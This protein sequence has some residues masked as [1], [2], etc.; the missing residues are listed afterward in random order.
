MQRI[1]AIAGHDLGNG[2]WRMALSGLC[3]SLIGI[4]LSRFAYTPLLP[5]LIAE[6]WFAPSQAAYLGAANLAGYLAGALLGQPL[7]SRVSAVTVLR[8]MMLVAGAAFFA[9]A[10]PLSFFWFFWWRFA[11]GLSG[12]VLMVLI[13]PT[14]LPHV[15]PSRR[16]LIGG[17]IFVGIGCGIV[18]SGTLVPALLR[19]G[20]AQTWTG[21][22]ILALALTGVAWNGWPAAEPVVRQ[23][24]AGGHRARSLSTSST[25]RALYLEYAL[26]AFGLVPHMIFLVDFV[27]RGLRLGLAAGAREWVVFG[28]G[29]MAGPVLAGYIADRIG[30]R[31]ALRFAFLIQAAAVAILTVDSGLISLTVSSV[32]IGG[33]VPGIVPLVLGRVHELVPEDAVLQKSA[34]SVCT[35]AFALGQAGGVYGLSYVFAQMGGAYVLL[36]IL[37]AGALV[38]ACAVDTM[39]VMLPTRRGKPKPGTA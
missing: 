17:A 25:L 6:H 29:A 18:G 20:L 13:A 34:W 5:A 37:G 32:I 4:G 30:F 21:L 31:L 7:T 27:A 15:A 22:G 28:L 26:N 11:A 23:T 10:Y 36:F 38:L 9:C 2:V 12:G 1:S 39:T 33:F 14:V 35:I 16:G 3:A 19:W 24:K 8:M